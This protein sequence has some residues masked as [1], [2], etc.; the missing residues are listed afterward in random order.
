MESV[1]AGRLLPVDR[2]QLQRIE[3]QPGQPQLFKLLAERPRGAREVQHEARWEGQRAEAADEDG[4]GGQ[5]IR[6]GVDGASEW[7]GWE[8]D[9][10]GGAG[11]PEEGDGT[12]DEY[13]DEG[14]VWLG[15]DGAAEPALEGDGVFGDNHGGEG[16]GDFAA[17][18]DDGGDGGNGAGDGGEG[19][20]DG[21]GPVGPSGAGEVSALSL[22][23]R[24]FR[25]WEDPPWL[26]PKAEPRFP[27]EELQRMRREA[28]QD[29]RYQRALRVA[30]A[31]GKLFA[32]VGCLP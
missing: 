30:Q 8:D 14:S 16:A 22:L 32:R 6:E 5:G 19:V 11:E 25:A 2:Y 15:D 31:S 20:C 24:P 21:I 10:D 9:G 7:G 3:H 4:E 29:P 12:P 28:L 23:G 27:P 1:A 13:D 17:N 18:D 26:A